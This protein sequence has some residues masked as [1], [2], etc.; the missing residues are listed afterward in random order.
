VL[1]VLFPYVAF[2]PWNEY[3]GF[4]VK[5]NKTVIQEETKKV[6]L[7]MFKPDLFLK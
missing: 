7:G 3:P 1:P 6:R 4:Y 5:K 2:F